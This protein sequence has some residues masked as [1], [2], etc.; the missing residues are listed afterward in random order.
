MFIWHFNIL[1]A[2]FST[3]KN[4]EYLNFTKNFIYGM[5][6]IF[7]IV[8]LLYF[9]YKKRA[10][11][12]LENKEEEKKMNLKKAEGRFYIKF[13]IGI[14]LFSYISFSSFSFIK[15]E[16]DIGYLKSFKP[17]EIL[18]VQENATEK[19]IK[20]AYRRLILKLE[21]IVSSKKI[22]HENPEKLRKE[23]RLNM[24]IATKAYESLIDHEQR[25]RFNLYG[26]PD[27]RFLS[28]ISKVIYSFVC[29][30]KHLIAILIS[31]LLIAYIE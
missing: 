30:L 13:I 17:L 14:I 2:V 8:A 7:L 23:A 29:N 10:V 5:Y 6:L 24:S 12:L 18:D 26:H 27:G 11:N 25:E 1:D 16:Y 31:I 28:R 4:D 20:K 3:L 19:E 15:A 21:M 22:Y 9:I